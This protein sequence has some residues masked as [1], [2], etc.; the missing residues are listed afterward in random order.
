MANER[1]AR[2]GL[3]C[4]VIQ[5]PDLAD[6]ASLLRGAAECC[7]CNVALQHTLFSLSSISLLLFRTSSCLEDA[8]IVG[9]LRRGR[10]L[11]RMPCRRRRAGRYPVGVGPIGKGCVTRAGLLQPAHKGSDAN[12]QS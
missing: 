6:A 8:R 5:R 3:D 2:R 7:I 9:S 1:R 12:C 4:L 11:L 10:R